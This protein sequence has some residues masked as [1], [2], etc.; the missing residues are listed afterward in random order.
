MNDAMVDSLIYT[1]IV[2][3]LLSQISEKMTTFLRNYFRVRTDEE[4]NTLVS[5]EA[6][7][8][9]DKPALFMISVIKRILVQLRKKISDAIVRL[10]R[11][12]LLLKN[13]KD[14]NRGRISQ[15]EKSEQPR[16]EFAI[17]KLSILIG[18]WVAF[19]FHAN[20]FD[21]LRV[22]YPHETLGWNGQIY[23]FFKNFGMLFTDK[24]GEASGY[25]K[26]LNYWRPLE[27]FGGFLGTGLLLSF[28]SKFFHDLLEILYSL[29][30]TKKALA[31]SELFKNI[32]TKK[33]LD[34]RMK[35]ES[36]DPIDLVIE[37]HA[38]NLRQSGVVSLEKKYSRDQESY[39]EI[40]VQNKE[41]E[42]ALKNYVFTYHAQGGSQILPPE[43]IRVFIQEP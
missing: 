2:L 37:L 20:I 43:I 31:D 33:E 38:A 26:A 14:I 9:S 24:V 16:I 22:D 4:K 3:L 19:A 40:V 36:R 10:I 35:L 6:T 28:G 12:M 27:M 15:V 41:S 23:S 39:L 11:Y 30:Q 25:F 32:R 21:M 7:P 17:S 5:P 29:K 1:G 8:D 18:F 13:D 42:S 34:E